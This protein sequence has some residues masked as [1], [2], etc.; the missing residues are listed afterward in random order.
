M[1]F[2][3]SSAD[4]PVELS[5]HRSVFSSIFHLPIHPSIRLYVCVSYERGSRVESSRAG[6]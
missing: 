4:S 1:F 5:R 6:I 2:F 3:M